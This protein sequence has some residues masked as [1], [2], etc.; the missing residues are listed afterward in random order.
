MTND[1]ALESNMPEGWASVPLREVSRPTR[2]RRE[3]QEFPALPYVGMEQ[4]ESQTRRLLG[5]VSA[6]QMKSTAFHFQKGDVLYGRLRPYLNKVWCAEFQGLCSSEFIVLPPSET[7]EPKYLAYYLSSRSFVDF[8]N[9][10]NQGD[11]PRVSYEQLADHD[12]PL[13]PRAEQRRIVAKVE[14]LLA[15]VQAT[16][17][18]L[19][20][21]AETL[22]RLRESILA[23]ACS[24]RLTEDWRKNNGRNAAAALDFGPPSP[25]SPRTEAEPIEGREVLAGII[26]HSWKLPRIEEVF[27]LID[28]R[29][30]NPKRS[31]HGK[32]LIT[33]K[34]IRMGRLS[35]EP[36]EYV[37]ESTYKHWM[38][39][40]FPQ[41]GD[42]LFVTEG[43]T[44]G[45]VARIDRDDEI[46]LAQRTLTLQPR[47][48]L[49]TSIF[50]YFMMSKYFQDLIIL[51]ATGSAAVGIKA[52]R[53]RSLPLPFPPLIEQNEI[54]NRLDALFKLVDAVEYRVAA[55][56]A[57]ADRLTEAILAKAF[58]GELV[59]TEAELARTEGRSFEPADQ[60]LARIRAEA[61]VKREQPNPKRKTAMSKKAGKTMTSFRHLV[62]VLRDSGKPM[63]AED[64]MSSAGYSDDTIEEFYQAL[65]DAVRKGSI[66]DPRDTKNRITLARVV[67]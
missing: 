33:A 64:L 35:N 6:T 26:P 16:R 65:R 49:D 11:R 2:P 25:K 29:G 5:T 34:N 51:N 41:K 23:A 58:D 57:Q 7:I 42:I 60:L 47:R 39:R 13:P 61:T 56:T 38:T 50:L 14:S 32:R 20:N 19:V 54:V 21:V 30:K 44:M 17:E 59:P 3:P 4:I 62:D 15:R 52:A 53:F 66:R 27:R 10:L 12:I 45:F 48:Q 67:K 28:Y 55:A 46:A 43:A 36:I 63:A 1:A 31:S 40:G 8:A 37:S 18:R 22:R 9:Q 24:G